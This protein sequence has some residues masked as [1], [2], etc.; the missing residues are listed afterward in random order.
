MS[1][2]ERSCVNDRKVG[3]VG[4]RV[5]GQTV[6]RNRCKLLLETRVTGQAMKGSKVKGNVLAF[7]NPHDVEIGEKENEKD[8]RLPK[9]SETKK[10]GGSGKTMKTTAKM[11][12][13][14]EERSKK[15]RGRRQVGRK[16][17]Q[18]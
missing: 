12:G 9:I 5:S 6:V 18:Q 10:P 8:E 11:R 13:L 15:G 16:G 1:A 2:D 14:S 17:Q 7:R 3:E 4:C